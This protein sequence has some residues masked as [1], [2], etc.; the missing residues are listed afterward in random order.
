MI[1]LA[2]IIVKK[3]KVNVKINVCLLVVYLSNDLLTFSRSC[4]SILIEKIDLFLAFWNMYI[5]QLR[6]RQTCRNT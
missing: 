6:S 4:L 3:G 5:N 2:F 1:F